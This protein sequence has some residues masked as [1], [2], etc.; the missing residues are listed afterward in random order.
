MAEP[1]CFFQ[2]L[3]DYVV[4]AN[5]CWIWQKS[6][7]RLGY[8]HAWDKERNVCRFAHR[9]AYEQAVGPIPEGYH[10]HHDCG[11]TSCINPRHLR[12]VSAREHLTLH[13]RRKLDYEAAVQ[14]RALWADGESMS[15]LA[16]IY[17]VSVGAIDHIVKGR[18]YVRA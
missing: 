3:D 16:R 9:M 8:P 11:T 14:I 13:G 2:H 1:R 5:G 10:V 4:D 18:S 7:G 17:E 15:S 6:C 12:A